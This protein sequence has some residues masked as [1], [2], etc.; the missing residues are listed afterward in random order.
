[1]KSDITYTGADPLRSIMGKVISM[2]GIQ[3]KTIIYLIVESLALFLMNI[4][5]YLR[6]PINDLRFFFNMVLAAV[7]LGASVN[8]KRRGHQ[9]DEDGDL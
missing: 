2:H 1:M 3:S 4:V 8:L 7:I 6:P 5:F 9:K